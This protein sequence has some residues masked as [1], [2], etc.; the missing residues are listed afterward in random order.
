M[1][2]LLAFVLTMTVAHA[3]DYYGPDG[4]QYLRSGN[5]LINPRN[6]DVSV[7]VGGNMYMD[8]RSG[9]V[10]QTHGGDDWYERRRAEEYG[11]R[12]QRHYY[13]RYENPGYDRYGRRSYR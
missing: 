5:M 1:K 2:L 3:Q 6:G 11:P 10:T 8:A 12:Y 9:R 7:D 13:Y 4:V